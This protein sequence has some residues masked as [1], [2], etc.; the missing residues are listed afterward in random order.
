M[1]RR[2]RQSPVP[3]SRAGP[4]DR[5]LDLD[6]D[7]N[8]A[9]ITLSMPTYGGDTRETS[10]DSTSHDSSKNGPVFTTARWKFIWMILQSIQSLAILIGIWSLDGVTDLQTELYSNVIQSPFS[11]SNSNR[12]D[13]CSPHDP[14]VEKTKTIWCSKRMPYESPLPLYW[15]Y[16]WVPM[17]AVFQYFFFLGSNTDGPFFSNWRSEHPLISITRSRNAYRWIEYA[18]SGSLMTFVVGILSSVTDINALLGLV[19]TNVATQYCG[20]L[21]DDNDR[22]MKDRRISFYAGVLIFSMT[23]IPMLASHIRATNDDPDV[24]T[25]VKVVVWGITFS[26][27]TFPLITSLRLFKRLDPIREDPATLR[28]G[29]MNALQWIAKSSDH[30]YDVASFISKALLGWT[31]VY[32]MS[33]AWVED[34]SVM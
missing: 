6:L 23:W 12:T 13:R 5:D 2:N 18:I 24:P 28:L 11:N 22:P 27:L 31:L 7:P 9:L 3:P 25:P 29:E 17:V 8:A 15:I 33:S 19:A 20:W 21:A 26:Y 10:M 16:L 32:G 4:L 30:W 1:L 34:R 14:Y